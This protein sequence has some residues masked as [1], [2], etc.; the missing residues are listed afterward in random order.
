MM[1][2]LKRNKYEDHACMPE[3]NKFLSCAAEAVS[4]CD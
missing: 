4:H 1:G 2:C 3:I